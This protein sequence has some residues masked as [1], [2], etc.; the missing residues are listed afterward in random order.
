MTTSTSVR[1]KR[2]FRVERVALSSARD[3]R[4]YFAQVREDPRVELSALT[5]QPTDRV[6]AVSSGGCTALSLLG[7]GAREVHAVDVNRTQNHIVELKAAAVGGL[8]RDAAIRFV[9]GWNMP[10]GRRL[11]LYH[12]LRGRLTDVARSYWD[13]RT[14][15]IERG[16]IN[17]GVSERF[18]RLVCR[19]VRNVVQ[20]PSRVERLLACRTLEEQRQ[21]FASEWDNRRWHWLFELLLNRWSM[22][23]AFDPRFFA[24][25]G[26]TG[27]AAHFRALANHALTGI[28][29]G[30]N[31]FLHHMLTG[32]YPADRPDGVPPYLGAQGCGVIAAGASGLLLVDGS[33]T[34][35]LRTLPDHSVNAFA[36]SNICEWLGD[37]DILELFHEVERV[38]APGARVVFRNFVGWTDVP[39]DCTRL[40]QDH[41]LGA[42]LIRSDRSA[43]QPRVVV[44]RVRHP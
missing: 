33:M 31:Y 3:D 20:T 32:R 27:F 22:S 8:S 43:L 37:Y 12:D 11:A 13:A 18:I 21:L 7:A 28:P 26:Q 10:R 1:V 6:V 17:A 44:C 2:A 39:P 4:L 15:A 14:A 5:V 41:E 38:A 30:D 16:V 25:A 29:I 19:L 34:E 23:R 42:T 35:H 24:G 40:E 36:L 9:G